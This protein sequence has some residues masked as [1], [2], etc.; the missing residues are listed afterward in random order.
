M[1]EEELDKD[2]R[3]DFEYLKKQV[4]KGVKRLAGDRT[5]EYEKGCYHCAMWKK[6]DKFVKD[7]YG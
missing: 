7:V 1:H 2:V 3:E 5:P 4:E 6:A